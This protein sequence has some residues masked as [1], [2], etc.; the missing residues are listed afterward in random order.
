MCRCSS[1]TS[2]RATGTRFGGC[3]TL[4]DLA[5]R[6]ARR[7]RHRHS[8]LHREFRAAVRRAG[9]LEFRARVRRGP[10]A[11]ALRALQQRPEVRDAARARARAS[12]PS[13]G[14]RS[15]RARRARRGTRALSA[16]ARRRPVEGPVVLPVFADAGAAR[17]RARFP[18]ASSPRTTCAT[19]ARAADCRSPTSRTARRSAS[20]RTATTRRSSSGTRRRP[21]G[22][23][24]SST[25]TAACSARHGGIHRFTI[26]QRKGSGSRRHRAPLY[27]V[28]DR[29]RRTGRSWSDRASALERTTLTASGVNWIAAS[30]PARRGA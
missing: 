7:R 6:A 30:P 29:R 26:G 9:R 25:T 16:A 27:V 18:S 15:L 2:A 11:A 4:D 23:A 1:T 17:A 3:C 10:D 8:A 24:R 20:C 12:A 21:R 13:S 22:A 19:H 14:D 28:G 5:R